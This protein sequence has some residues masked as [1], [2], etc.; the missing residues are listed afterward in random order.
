MLLFQVVA[1]L[2]DLIQVNP[3]FTEQL[4]VFA[5]FGADF[6]DISRLADIAISLVSTADQQQQAALEMLDVP[7]RFALY[8][9]LE[10]RHKFT[11]PLPSC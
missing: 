3:L 11:N 9:I 10:P 2:R 8:C 5:N 6:T 4:R 7:E 1:A